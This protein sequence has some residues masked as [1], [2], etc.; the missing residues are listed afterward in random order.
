MSNINIGR[1]ILFIFGSTSIIY[2]MFYSKKAHRK[3][4]PFY[5][6]TGTFLG[7]I[8]VA[9]IAVLPWYVM[10]SIFILLG[11]LTFVLFAISFF[12]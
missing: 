11:I 6:G 2:G 5:G 12:P 1:I 10:K 9:I 8:V 4:A 7:E 3:A